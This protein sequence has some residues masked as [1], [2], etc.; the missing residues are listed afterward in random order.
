MDRV[1]LVIDDIQYAGHLE[2]TLRKVGFDIE[3]MTNEYSLTEKILTFNP[4]YVIV[5]GNNSRV[6]SMSVGKKLRESTKFPGKVILIFTEDHKSTPEEFIKVRMDLLLFEPMSALRLVI[7]LLNMTQLDKESITDK[8]LR[9]A[10]TDSQFRSY[11]SQLLKS[12]GTTIDS[13]IQVITGELHQADEVIELDTEDLLSFGQNKKSEKKETESPKSLP[14]DQS[15]D[16]SLIEKLDMIEFEITE[17]FKNKLKNELNALNQELPLRIESYNR[18]IKG[19]DQD[20][21]KGL[22]K[23]KTRTENKKLFSELP[24]DKTKHQDV[25]RRKFVRAL[26]KK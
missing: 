8:L 15:A 18:A 11:E 14:T 2:M 25:E 10:H 1:L 20:L 23:R 9:F 5:K 19:V 13:E 7:N 4:D 24:E 17:D 21:K 3:T 26:V 6:S 12:A 22:N 16:L